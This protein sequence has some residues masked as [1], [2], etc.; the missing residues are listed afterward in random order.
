MSEISS[1]NELLTQLLRLDAAEMTLTEYFSTEFYNTELM[2]YLDLGDPTMERFRLRLQRKLED[3]LSH[4]DLRLDCLQTEQSVEKLV[5]YERPRGKGEEKI[6]SY[7]KLQLS[8][9]I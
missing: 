2:C 3:K 5:V 6:L 9:H 4:T 1:F 7:G 8:L